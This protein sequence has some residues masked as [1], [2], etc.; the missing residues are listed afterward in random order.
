MKKFLL[1][2]FTFVIFNSIVFTS[3]T[4]AQDSDF[5]QIVDIGAAR[6]LNHMRGIASEIE[7]ADVQKTSDDFNLPGDPLHAWISI[8]GKEKV[9]GSLIF[10]VNGD[11]YVST[12]GI[13]VDDEILEQIINAALICVGLTDSEID[14]LKNSKDEM[15]NVFCA[16]MHRRIFIDRKSNSVLIFATGE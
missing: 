9:Q 12:I 3:T 5:V 14:S 2:I 8:F 6:F 1:A 16:N 7:F 11:G 15:Q 13:T 10:F 4:H